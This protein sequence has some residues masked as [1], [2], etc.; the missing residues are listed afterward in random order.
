[1]VD[2]DGIGGFKSSSMAI[3]NQIDIGPSPTRDFKSARAAN[4]TLVTDS[5]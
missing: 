3:S 2:T 5:S 1:M 4:N